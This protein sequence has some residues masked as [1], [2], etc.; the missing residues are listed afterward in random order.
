MDS[1]KLSGHFLILYI[2]VMGVYCL[3]NV[4]KIHNADIY[5][6]LENQPRKKQNNQINL[7]YK[8]KLER[9]LA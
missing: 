4:K 8:Q 6:T 3:L 7:Y 2:A 1:C 5:I 9:H